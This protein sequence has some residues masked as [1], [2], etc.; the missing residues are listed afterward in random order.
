MEDVAA[1]RWEI[2]MPAAPPLTPKPIKPSK[3]E[4]IAAL[5][6]MQAELIRIGDLMGMICRE[7]GHPKIANEWRGIRTVAVT[8]SN[9]AG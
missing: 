6:A 2:V 7:N 8:G 5:E 9:N 3:R 1:N 4:R